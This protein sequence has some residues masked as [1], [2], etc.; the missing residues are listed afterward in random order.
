[1]TRIIPPRLLALRKSQNCS[2]GRHNDGRC[3]LVGTLFGSS[4]SLD[5][6]APEPSSSLGTVHKKQEGHTTGIVLA[7]CTFSGLSKL[8]D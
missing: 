4:Q 1:M 7:S 8:V 6:A 5:K 3:L 2:V